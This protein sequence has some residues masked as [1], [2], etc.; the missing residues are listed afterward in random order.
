MSRTGGGFGG[1]ASGKTPRRP[2]APLLIPVVMPPAQPRI[3]TGGG[4]G[5][6]YLE[7]HLVKT[8]RSKVGNMSNYLDDAHYQ[9]V[10]GSYRK[11]CRRARELGLRPLPP[12]AIPR[13][14]ERG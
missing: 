3:I 6:S 1:Q 11:R 8:R 4:F 13:V 9:R 14:W 12:P 10:Q 7:E 5:G 2:A